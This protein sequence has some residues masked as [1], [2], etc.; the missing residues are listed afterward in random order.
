VQGHQNRLGQQVRLPERRARVALQLSGFFGEL[1]DIGRVVLEEAL[2]WRVLDV[3]VEVV[4]EF[5]VAW[6]FASV[7][8]LRIA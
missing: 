3:L 6:G 7:D 1:L 5:D 8:F 4:E 2:V